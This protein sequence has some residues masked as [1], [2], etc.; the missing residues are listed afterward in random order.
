MFLN[1]V[2]FL[3]GL[4]GII[5]GADWLTD[6]AAAIAKRLGVPTI[7]VGLTIVA[8]GSS[9]PEFV[10]SVMSSV[11]GSGGMAVGNVV[12]SNIFNILIILGV[13]AAIRPLH[14]SKASVRNDLPFALLSS[15]VTAIVAYDG[16]VQ[17]TEGLLM[18]CF[19]AIFLSYTFSLAN[20]VPKKENTGDDKNVAMPLWQSILWCLAGFGALILGGNWL[21]D[22]STA[23]ALAMGIP[24]SI[25]ALT[26][27]ST[28]TSAPELAA[29]V[30][31]ARKGD[32]GMAVGN[33]VGSVVFNA[34]FVLGTAGSISAL[35]VE[36][37]TPM[38]FG[39][40]LIA[41]VLLWVFARFGQKVFTLS[42]IEGWILLFVG[43]AYYG[44]LV[45][46]QIA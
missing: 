12:G 25:V 22:G 39:T 23:I 27:V 20:N 24:E 34:F 4:L 46:L 29:S 44:W 45:Y 33:V 3:V 6:G 17:R 14:I 10:V 42:R 37:V 9:L 36:G 7:V 43:L 21:V 2:Y 31:A 16:I 18:L 32:H 8:M 30:V 19:F 5:K 13:T 28:G 15:V 40:L 26:I 41:S 38:Y 35:R 11:K 1:I